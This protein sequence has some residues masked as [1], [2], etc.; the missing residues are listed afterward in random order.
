MNAPFLS[1]DLEPLVSRNDTFLAISKA[2]RLCVGRGKVS[3]RALS[4][5]AGVK[6]RRIECA[7]CEPGD[8]ERRPLH[9][10]EVWSLMKVLRAP[11][12]TEAMRDTELVTSDLPNPDI[13]PG[14]FVAKC[15]GN[16]TEVALLFADGRVTHCERP[17]AKNIGHRMIADGQKLVA[18]GAA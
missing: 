1:A 2:L 13:H 18:L 6:E 9:I 7:M 5:R 16:T 11:F 10:E 3:V 17:K 4:Q 12:A 15:S 14:E 8:P